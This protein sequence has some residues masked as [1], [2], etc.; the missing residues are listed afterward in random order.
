M[1][2]KIVAP[3]GPETLL[4]HLS[5]LLKHSSSYHFGIQPLQPLHY[6]INDGIREGL[7]EGLHIAQCFL[8]DI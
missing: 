8:T 2:L 1:A 5:V 4:L 7:L 3:P 6:S